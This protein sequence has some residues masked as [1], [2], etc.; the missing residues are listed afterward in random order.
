M[1]FFPYREERDQVDMLVPR[2]SWA[3]DVSDA[4]PVV[5]SGK[6]IV[7]SADFDRERSELLAQA[8]ALR[9]YAESMLS[10]T[11]MLMDH[12]IKAAMNSASGHVIV[13][14]SSFIRHNREYDMK[15]F[16]KTQHPVLVEFEN[17]T[18]ATPA[19]AEFHKYYCEWAAELEWYAKRPAASPLSDDKPRYILS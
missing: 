15:A 2:K 17:R 10:Q 3:C 14:F 5:Y 11:P 16:A 18:A 8:P 13:N 6:K 1:P 9:D 19:L 4:A 7:E 12:L